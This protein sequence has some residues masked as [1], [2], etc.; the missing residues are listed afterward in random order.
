VT[1]TGIPVS[2]VSTF[3][4]SSPV[5]SRSVG[6]CDGVRTRCRPSAATAV[7]G[8]RLSAAVQN[9]RNAMMRGIIGGECTSE[10]VFTG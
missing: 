4:N 7:P 1:R 6:F 2:F 10:N 5:A 9:S 3:A 8:A